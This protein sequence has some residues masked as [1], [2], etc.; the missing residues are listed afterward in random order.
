M[1]FRQYIITALLLAPSI[2]Y[3]DSPESTLTEVFAPTFRTLKVS[4]P[5]RFMMPP[6]LSENNKLVVSF[7]EISD[8]FR[9]LRYRLV[10]C[11][12]DW[13]PSRLTDPEIL[14]S[15]NIA[16]IEDFAQSY[17]TFIHYYNYRVVLP[18][19]YMHPKVSGNYL[20]QIF[21][22]EDEDNV[23]LQARFMISEDAVKIIPQVTSNT[24]RG[25]NTEWQQLSFTIDPGQTRIDNPFSDIY[26]KVIQNGRDEQARII[27]HPQRMN[28]GEIIYDHLPSLIFPAGNEYRR[29]E[30]VRA[31]YPG[32][33]ADSVRFISPSYHSWLA[34]DEVRNGREYI[35]DR[36]QHG[37]FMVREFNSTDSD[38]GADYVMVNFTLD[39]PRVMNGDIYVCGEMSMNRCLPQFKMAYDD[40]NGVYRLSLPLKQG[41]YNYQYRIMPHG[42]NSSDADPTP[43]EGNFY[44]TGNE[45]TILVYE[46]RP[47]QRADRLLG[48]TTIYTD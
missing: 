25:H 27:T 3:A 47:G 23:L 33:H 46:R 45:Y 48:T 8:D 30:T 16:D 44:E 17:N 29:F 28:G 39:S 6:I 22:E 41:S 36:T 43:I 37:R 34:I 7:D 21:D 31:D 9:H 13:T 15:F 11:N 24:D 4:D 20:L 10:H 26:V 12:A 5:M 2:A 38:L 14:D 35:Y 19:E 42:G 40:K 18:S 32:M 1:N